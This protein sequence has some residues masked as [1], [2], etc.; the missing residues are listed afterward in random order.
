MLGTTQG[1][2]GSTQV[3]FGGKP[4][5]TFA[6]DTPGQVTGNGFSDSFGGTHFVWTAAT[7]SGS[8]AGSAPPAT[9]QGSSGGNS[10]GGY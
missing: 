1:S 9:T 6:E 8:S 7:V 3:T 10:S 2:D 5:Y 4:L